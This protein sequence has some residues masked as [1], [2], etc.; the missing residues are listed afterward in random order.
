[1]DNVLLV[2]ATRDSEWIQEVM[3]G[4][5]PAEL[6]VAGRRIVEYAVE[7][8]RKADELFIEVL[9]WHFSEALSKDFSDLTRTACPV[10]YV[11]GEGAI[12]EGLAD[13]EGLSTPLTETILDGLLVV[14]GPVV[15]DPDTDGGGSF[16]PVTEEQL[17]RT[18]PGVYRREGG[19]WLVRSPQGLVIRDVRMWHRLNFSALRHPEVFP[20]PGYSAEKG[21]YLGR[22]VVMERGVEIKPPVLVNDDAWCARNVRFEGS[23]IVGARSYVGEGTRLLR[24]MVGDDTFVGDGLDF[25]DKII[26]GSRV[27][28]VKTGVWTDVEDVGVAHRIGGAPAQT[29]WLRRI[30]NLIVGSSRGRRD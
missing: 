2:P 4:M 18:P 25:E 13:I 11:Q 26:V 19:R 15:P 27:I 7:R 1:M 3:P 8:A 17:R 28:D 21:V 23:V 12:P 6:P 16:T 24:T 30:W 9:D 5:S 10:F 22:N 29:G 20:L 14:W